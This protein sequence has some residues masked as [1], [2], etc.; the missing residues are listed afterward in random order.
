MQRARNVKKATENGGAD[1]PALAQSKPCNSQPCLSV[2]FGQGYCDKALRK[3]TT[4]RAQLKSCGQVRHSFASEHDKLQSMYVN[5]GKDAE[6]VINGIDPDHSAREGGSP[7]KSDATPDTDDEDDVKHTN[8]ATKASP[9]Q[10]KK[11]PTLVGEAAYPK[12][13]KPLQAK[14]SIRFAFPRDVAPATIKEAVAAAVKSASKPKYDQFDFLIEPKKD[15]SQLLQIGEGLDHP[16]D[17]DGNIIF[18]EMQQ[19][20]CAKL[21]AAAALYCGQMVDCVQQSLDS[22][23]RGYSRDM[24]NQVKKQAAATGVVTTDERSFATDDEDEAADEKKSETVDSLIP[25]TQDELVTGPATIPTGYTRP[26][27]A[28]EQSKLTEGELPKYHGLKPNGK[29]LAPG[30]LNT[31]SSMP[32]PEQVLGTNK[33]AAP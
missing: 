3:C 29:G 11:P 12:M 1:C 9:T 4:N 27:T 2:T 18:S 23:D 24:T 31:Q 20:Q 26:M 10:A 6:K 21:Q 32:E 33:K 19:E 22:A 25:P 15:S 14:P 30:I 13:K 17:A 16:K 8:T 28:L 5:N 7:E